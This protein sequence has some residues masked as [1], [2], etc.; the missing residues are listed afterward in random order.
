MNL[1]IQMIL[2]SPPPRFEGFRK[3]PPYSFPIAWNGIGEKALYKNRVT[4]KIAI[5]DWL[6][7]QLVPLN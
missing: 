4:F 2:L 3:Y 1:E 7:D 5:R 6:F